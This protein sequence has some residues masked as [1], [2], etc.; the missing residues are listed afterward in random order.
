[1]ALAAG[2]PLNGFLAIAKPGVNVRVSGLTPLFALFEHLAVLGYPFDL[3]KWET[4]VN[5]GLLNGV[6]STPSNDCQVPVAVEARLRTILDT[7]RR[8]AAGSGIDKLAFFLVIN[9]LEGVPAQLVS[10]YLLNSIEKFFVAGDGMVRRL[11]NRPARLGPV[12][13]RKL[14]DAMAQAVVGEYPPAMPSRSPAYQQLLSAGFSMYLR[15]N[16]HNR[17]PSPHRRWMRIITPDFLDYQWLP[18]K[19]I[20]DRASGAS[21]PALVT[22]EP[23]ADK[24][25]MLARL[26]SEAQ[27]HPADLLQAV[28]DAAAIV[29]AAAPRFPELSQPLVFRQRNAAYAAWVLSLSLPLLAAGLFRVGINTRADR[30]S[31]LI[32]DQ[33][34]TGLEAILRTVLL[35]WHT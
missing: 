5:S 14:A 9:G 23:A 12:S 18:V 30:Y 10:E 32:P 1:M 7:E 6:P 8:L 4:L 3:A 15:S 24:D 35:Y 19:T 20:A 29:A 21:A 17:R 25:R 2:P 28:K 16:W 34:E 27:A 13:E 33:K 31:H 26:R 11:T 22:M